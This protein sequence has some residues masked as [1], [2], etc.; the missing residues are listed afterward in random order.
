MPLNKRKNQ[1]KWIN[2]SIAFA[3][4]FLFGLLNAP[5]GLPQE[6]MYVTGIFIGCLYLWLTVSTV[7]GGLFCIFMLTT[8]P[9]TS[10]AEVFSKGFGSWIF[11]F[12]V[13]TFLVTHALCQTNFVLR[14]VAFF[15]TR[16]F[17]LKNPWGFLILFYSALTLV[18]LFMHPAPLILLFITIVDQM[19]REMELQPGDRTAQMIMLGGIYVTGI[20]SAMTPIHTFPILAIAMYE[21]KY[22]ATINYTSYMAFSI[23]TGIAAIACMMLM[24]RFLYKPDM[25]PISKVDV[26]RLKNEISPMDLREKMIVTVFA[27]VVVLWL[28]PGFLEFIN[29][30]LAAFINSYGRA[31]PPLIGTLI[32][33]VVC[34]DGK[35]LLDVNDGLKNGVKWPGII[36]ACSVVSLS[37]IM[38]SP[39]V[40]ITNFLFLVF[41]PFVLSIPLWSF[42]PLIA[43]WGLMQTNLSSNMVCL[44]LMFSVTVPLAHSTG[45]VINVAAVACICGFVAACGF[46]TPSATIHSSIAYGS[47]W[48]D[49]AVGA[50]YGL[51]LAAV[52]ALPIWLIGY[53]IL[54]AVLAS[55]AL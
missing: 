27:G 8:V 42:I 1:R 10:A 18:G 2:T 31:V 44:V 34:V 17:A 51:L 12:L 38:A 39:E 36:L 43:L 32:L 24:F 13:T 23:I 20:S 9:S 35:P 19:F 22:G 50:K 16:K 7:W 55:I 3:V 26:F 46:A 47:K 25:A 40:G 37:E 49:V 52:I 53:P 6:G 5:D 28:T 33:A 21:E 48:I 29:K 11:I 15:L 14:C 4:T 54:N 30:D 41:K 45:G